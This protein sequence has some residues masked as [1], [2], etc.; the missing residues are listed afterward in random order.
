MVAMI[1]MSQTARP[2]DGKPVGG[3]FGGR[4]VADKSKST[5]EQVVPTFRVSKT[6]RSNRK[7]RAS[8][9]KSF[10]QTTSI[11][12]RVGIRVGRYPRLS[13]RIS[14][15]KMHQLQ[16]FSKTSFRARL[17]VRGSQPPGTAIGKD[18]HAITKP[19]TE[20]RPK[21]RTKKVGTNLPGH[22]PT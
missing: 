10:S 3:R 5:S 7:V 14:R 11:G 2:V 22:T 12:D 9:N 15:I 17:K 19:I 20:P 4:R 18:N 6:W 1:E 13:E 8:L 16:W 21:G